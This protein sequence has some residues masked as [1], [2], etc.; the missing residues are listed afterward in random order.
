MNGMLK[1]KP[2]PFLILVGFSAVIFILSMFSCSHADDFQEHDD[3]PKIVF[4]IAMEQ[5]SVVVDLLRND[6]Y[7]KALEDAKG[8]AIE[9][10]EIRNMKD[11]KENADIAFEGAMITD[12]VNWLVP[13]SD[14][15]R[16]MQLTGQFEMIEPQFGR[17]G[18][19]QYGFVFDEGGESSIT[20]RLVVNRGMLD[21]AGIGRIRYDEESVEALLAKLSE[22][23]ATPLAVYGCPA[24][25]GF[26][27]LLG[28]FGLS[29]L[30]GNEYYIDD[31]AMHM[32]KVEDDAR[33][34]LA[35]VRLLH[36]KA[37]IPE[38]FLSLNEYSCR[39]LFLQGRCAMTMVPDDRSAMDLVNSAKE[40]GMH[41]AVEELPVPEGLLDTGVFNRT[42]GMVARYCQHPDLI[43]SVFKQLQE[44]SRTHVKQNP[45]FPMSSTLFDGKQQGRHLQDIVSKSFLDYRRFYEK[46]LMDIEIIK[47]Y[48]CQIAVGNMEL[49]A[50]ETMKS[51]WINDFDIN[52]ESADNN[53]SG[54]GLL[55]VL[56][57]WATR[58]N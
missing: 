37:Y 38:H 20:P 19:K 9:L 43:L 27:V 5:E 39:I 22:Q 54:K 36:K 28:L 29:P 46:H 7:R 40:N 23:T 18:G 51:E 35:F 10:N 55:Q 3:R 17:T 42:I 14:D 2:K 48:Y 31:G 41:V 21:S 58:T 6:A 26:A 56:Y 16:I 50:F 13:F 30:E 49:D 47:P 12:Y 8:V 57:A 52:V 25:S 45:S 33:E 15:A 1:H 24:E 34:Y 11:L 32:D 44:D 4:T 53:L